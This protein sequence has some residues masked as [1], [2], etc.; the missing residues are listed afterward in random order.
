MQLMT[1]SE[2]TWKDQHL[3]RKRHIAHDQALCFNSSDY[4]G[5]SQHPV[6]INA[7]QIGL[8]QYGLS[9]QGSALVNGY[10]KIHHE[11]E[12]AFAEFTGFESAVFFSSGYMANLSLVQSLLSHTDTVFY[13]Q[14]CHASLIDSLLLS[15]TQRIRY[16]HCDVTELTQRLE[17]VSTQRHILSNSVFSTTGSLCDLAKLVALKTQYAT[18]LMIDDAH[19][20]AVLGES[21]RGSISHYQLDPTQFSIVSYPLSKGF[22]CF[23]AM[24]C[25][26]KAV[27]DKIIQ[28]GRSYRYSSSIPPLFAY[29][30][31]KVLEILQKEPQHQQ[32]LRDRIDYFKQ[33]TV[34]LNVIDSN[35]AIQAIPIASSAA[36]MALQHHLSSV[37]FEVG[38]L[39]PPSVPPKK[40]L[41][42]IT[43]NVKHSKND[44]DCLIDELKK[45]AL[46]NRSTLL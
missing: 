15:R 44:I 34:G 27:I 16:K 4:L 23:G 3:L 28:F 42:R 32:K 22:G 31:L 20:L 36:A 19:G 6:V 21:G 40:N 45:H 33:K 26:G 25:G 24:L 38:C 12:C 13:D 14:Y 8:T 46:N 1:Y 7:A 17:S 5:L 18:N 9:S 30:G 39:R 37:G 2:K 43:L 41:L 10:K 35:T 29:A 11:F